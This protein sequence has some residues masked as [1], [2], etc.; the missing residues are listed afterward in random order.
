MAFIMKQICIALLLTTAS[1]LCFAQDKPATPKKHKHK[2]AHATKK[3]LPEW[4]IA[5]NY[6]ATA[7]VYFPD[8][9]TFYD[10]ARGGY[11]YWENGKYVF[12][13]ALPPFLEKV[14]L[15]KSRVQ[16]LKNISLNLHPESDYPHYMEMYPADHENNMVPVPIPGNPAQ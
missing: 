5:H 6:D 8:Y 4:A 2:T 16:I 15:N 9:Y 7:H 1:V 10:P 3:A 14:D 11:L 12:T 13:P